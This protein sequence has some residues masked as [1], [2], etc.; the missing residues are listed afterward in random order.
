[1]IKLK[2][3]LFVQSFVVLFFMTGVIIIILNQV[4]YNKISV[5]T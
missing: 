1:M 3:D 5:N 4:Q 2:I